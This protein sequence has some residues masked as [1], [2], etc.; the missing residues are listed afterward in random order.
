LISLGALPI[1]EENQRKSGSG[2]E[3]R[4]KDWMERREGKL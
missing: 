4:W 3:R 2:G 1:S